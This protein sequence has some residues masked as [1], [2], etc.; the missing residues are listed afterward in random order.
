MG[1]NRPKPVLPNIT[2][3]D[4]AHQCLPKPGIE[5]VGEITAD[6]ASI[7]ALVAYRSSSARGMPL[8]RRLFPILFVKLPL[9]EEPVGVRLLGSKVDDDDDDD[10][11]RFSTKVFGAAANK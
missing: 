2:A 4:A 7:V 6:D 10:D 5:F 8:L 11:W 1:P 9:L 3:V